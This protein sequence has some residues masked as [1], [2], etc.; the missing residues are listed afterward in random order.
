VVALA[1]E[2]M[3]N[4]PVVADLL[5]G[6][7][8]ANGD[9]MSIVD[10]DASVVT[11]GGRTLQFGTDFILDGSELSLNAAGLAQFDSLAEGAQESVTFNF[12]VSDGT[13]ATPNT[14]TL[15]INGVTTRRPPRWL[16]KRAPAPRTPPS[17]A[18]CCQARMPRAMR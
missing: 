12:G 3:E 5:A 6:A 18:C 14:L 9:P 10:L 2:A 1:A 15:T 7:A 8:D 4:E 17:R 16:P 13:A 11:A